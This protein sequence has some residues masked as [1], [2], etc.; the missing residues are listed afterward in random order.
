MKPNK[1]SRSLQDRGDVNSNDRITALA[2]K[3]F[4]GKRGYVIGECAH[5]VAKAGWE[6]GQRVCEQ[7]PAPEPSAPATR[8]RPARPD[9]GEPLLTPSEVARI[10]KVDPKTVSRWANQGKLGSVRTLGNH[11]RFRESEIRAWIEDSTTHR[12]AG[13]NGQTS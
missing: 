2:G 10:F 13:A 8:E 3:Q 7:C 5:A 6:A 12:T 1:E 9:P 11:R 4:P